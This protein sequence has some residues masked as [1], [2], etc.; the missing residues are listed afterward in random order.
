MFLFGTLDERFATPVLADLALHATG[1]TKEIATSLLM[2]QA[3]PEALAVL[4]QVKPAG[5]SESAAGSLQALQTKPD[6]IVPRPSPKTSRADFI[7]ALTA[8]LN[9]NETPFNELIAS[10]P[11]GERDLVAVATPADLDLLRKV[12]RYYIAKNDQHAIEWYDQ[13]SQILMTLVWRARS[14][15][16]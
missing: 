1:A 12:R 11:D 15:Q 4:P 10:V 9:G 7:A 16:P 13:F 6:L 5:L 8:L 3:T 2:S 14:A